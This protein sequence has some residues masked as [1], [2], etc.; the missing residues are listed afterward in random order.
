MLDRRSFTRQIAAGAAAP[1]FLRNLISAPRYDTVRLASFGAGGMAWVT[2]EQIASHPKVKLACVAEVDSD[3]LGRLKQK[4]PEARIY[5][6]FRQ[7][8]DKEHREVDVACVGTPD[9]M[10]APIAMAAMHRGLPVYVQKPLAHDIYEIRRLTMFA[11][12]KNLVTQMG[13]QNHSAKEYRTAAALIQAGAIGK[14]K[15]VHSW[16]EKKWGDPDPL[17]NQTDTPPSTLNWDL[18][19]G[20]AAAR[21]FIGGGYYHPMNWRKRLDF[22]TATFGDMGCHIFDPVFTALRLTAPLS[23]RSE[24]PAPN[25]HNWAINTII[26]YVF[27]GT[28]V[29]E[30]KTIP[31]SWYDGDE[32][33]PQAV[34]S[35]LGARKAPGQGSIFVGTKG[36]MLLPHMTMP[37]LLP[38]EQFRDFPM[39]QHVTESHYHQWIEAVRGNCQASASFDYSGPLTESVLLGPVATRFPKTTLEWNS[40]KLKFTNSSEATAFIPRQYRNGWQVKGL[41]T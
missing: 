41:S 12:K 11:R 4:Y 17:P 39:P 26:H 8:L 27:P 21:P 31:I 13:I 2:L 25:A 9:H 1:F 16:S 7:L 38:E 32:R 22:G 10:H 24:G 15:E 34:L 35:L 28:E 37:V 6:D 3:N 19:L 18:W 29:T 36:T 23:V 20:V 40:A 33:P 5:E 14:I 30:E